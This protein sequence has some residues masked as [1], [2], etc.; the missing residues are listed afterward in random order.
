MNIINSLKNIFFSQN[1][2]KS[3]SNYIKVNTKTSNLNKIILTNFTKSYYK[4]IFKSNYKKKKEKNE[5]K[6]DIIIK[7]N[8]LQKNNKEKKDQFNS[9]KNSVNKNFLY[10][11]KGAVYIIEDW[12]KKIL[13]KKEYKK[14][15]LHRNFS[16]KNYKIF[17]NK[18]KTTSMLISKNNSV[19]FK[20][21]VK[22]N[23]EVINTNKITNENKSIN[24]LNNF[25]Y[26]RNNVIQKKE[27]KS[28]NL[29][30]NESIFLE[31]NTYEDTLINSDSC[32]FD[33]TS[34]NNQTIKETIY[35]H[36]PHKN[37]IKENN[38]TKRET[39][40]IYPVKELNNLVKQDM[41]KYS[42]KNKIKENINMNK[43]INKVKPQ[44]KSDTDNITIL[45]EENNNRTLINT[46]EQNYALFNEIK[47]KIKLDSDI[48]SLMQNNQLLK[49]NPLDESSI[50][51]N[52]SDLKQGELIRNVNVHIRLKKNCNNSNN[53]ITIKNDDD[54]NISS[55]LNENKNQEKIKKSKGDKNNICKNYN[56]KNNHNKNTNKM[57]FENIYKN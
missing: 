45:W 49:E 31:Q 15:M 21:L 3:D 30:K 27:F 54:Q 35:I 11:L 53:S 55:F 7:V 13:D 39:N 24:D 46:L 25:I 28:V 16:D 38:I 33:F 41:K 8:K 43:Y 9:R 12:W 18:S 6:T 42:Q 10:I 37:N 52:N 1:D 14:R 40:I 22:N 57:K 34:N 56:D 26:Y 19:N 29:P 23:T 2:N 44:K 51:L 36:N 4:Y 50:Y 32:F 5:N 17:C 47:K 20:N 48:L